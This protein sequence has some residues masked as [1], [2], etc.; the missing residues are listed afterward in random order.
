[1]KKCPHFQK[2]NQNLCPLD[3]ELN[4]RTGGEG[5]KCRWMRE[6]KLKK[7][8]GKHFMS[9]GGVMPSASLNCVPQGNLE[10]LNESSREAWVLKGKGA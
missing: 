10:W 1:M 7:I 8:G 2:C 4:L 9:G 5:D 3:P 6:P